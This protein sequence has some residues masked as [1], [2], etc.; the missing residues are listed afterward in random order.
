MVDHDLENF[1]DITTSGHAMDASDCPSDE[2]LELRTKF[3]RDDRTI[4]FM[5]LAN[6]TYVAVWYHLVLP[7]VKGLDPLKHSRF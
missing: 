2:V 4:R 3:I 7:A 6:M 1:S 5:I